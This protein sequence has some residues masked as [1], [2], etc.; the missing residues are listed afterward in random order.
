MISVSVLVFGFDPEPDLE[1]WR[2]GIHTN[3]NH[4]VIGVG[5]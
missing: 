3:L 5:I 4:D 1:S 2:T